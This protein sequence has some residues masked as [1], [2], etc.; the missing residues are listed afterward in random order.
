M[1]GDTTCFVGVEIEKDVPPVE[2]LPPTTTVERWVADSGRLQFMTPSADYMVNYREG[3]GIVRISDGRAMP[4]E[5]IGNL[6]MSFWSG[7]D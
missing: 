5:G 6:R 2:E 7:K 3:G 4:I 1:G